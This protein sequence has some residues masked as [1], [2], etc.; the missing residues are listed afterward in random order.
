[1][2]H[3]L[4]STDLA[5]LHDIARATLSGLEH[6]YIDGIPGTRAGYL[7]TELRASQI[8]TLSGLSL[9]MLTYKEAEYLGLRSPE[10]ARERIQKKLDYL[11]AIPLSP[12]GLIPQF[13]INDGGRP[14]IWDEGH[15]PYSSVDTAW[16]IHSLLEIAKDSNFH[17]QAVTLIAKFLPGLARYWDKNRKQFYGQLGPDGKPISPHLYD[18]L[19]SEATILADIAKR[20]GLIPNAQDYLGRSEPNS[21]GKSVTHDPIA[22]SRSAN[23]TAL[24][25]FGL[26][27]L[28]P[29]SIDTDL[30]R[31]ATKLAHACLDKGHHSAS[32]IGR[33]LYGVL[34]SDGLFNSDA[35]PS[36]GSTVALFFAMALCPELTLAKFRCIE[37]RVPGL[38]SP[39][40]G[41]TD[42][43]NIKTGE[44]LDE[45]S[46]DNLV[47]ITAAL[48]YIL[49]THNYHMPTLI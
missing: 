7:G 18:L 31:L 29:G 46:L 27:V 8:V 44:S 41:P 11:Q 5:Q 35:D 39:N 17:D 15:N 9:S 14:A 40:T 19:L 42:H 13:T 49:K 43:Y 10:Q 6:L 12:A 3:E 25:K 16:T 21:T 1:M 33:N 24:E 22:N 34:G 36:E 26:A 48:T 28:A 30:R 23:G 2:G 47:M 45:P 20:T 37:C 32:Y 4:R 38:I